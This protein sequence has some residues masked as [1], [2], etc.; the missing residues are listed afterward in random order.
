MKRGAARREFVSVPRVL[1]SIRHDDKPAS[2]LAPNGRNGHFD[3]C[4]AMNGGNDW[5]DLE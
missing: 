1:G 5:H 3:L 4:V 2:R